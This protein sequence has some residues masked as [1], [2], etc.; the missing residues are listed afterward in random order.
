MKQY[1]QFTFGFIGTFGPWH[2]INILE[3]LI[4][5]FA[6]QHESV[7]FLMIGDGVLLPNLKSIVEK[8]N[9]TESYVTFTSMVPQSQSVQYLQQCDAFL[10]PTQPNKDGSPFFGSPTKL[11]EYMSMAKP[12]IASDLG[13]LSEVISPALKISGK[14]QMVPLK[15]EDEVGILVDPLDMQGFVNA[16]KLCLHLPEQVRQK[17]GNNARQKVLKKYTWKQHV[18][19]IVDFTGL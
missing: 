8:L 6:S 5:A 18:Q 15:I 4:E 7:H 19:R 1:K 14:T 17:M 16:C 12:I 2:G 11:F 13:Q 10:C 3:Y 9:I